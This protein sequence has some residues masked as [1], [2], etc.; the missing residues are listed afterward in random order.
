MARGRG[1]EVGRELSL[2]WDQ[3]EHLA[4]RGPAPS[5]AAPNSTAS[6][7]SAPSAAGSTPAPGGRRG[8]RL[9]ALGA[10]AALVL[11]LL[12]GLPRLG[13]GADGPEEVAR[14]FLQAMVDGDLETV[15]VH[16]R[17]VPDASPAALTAEVLE[18]AED[19]LVSAEIL[20][21][22]RVADTAT[23]T[24]RLVTSAT[25]RELV[26]PL[27]A[28]STGA[29]S[30]VRWEIVPIELPETLV[31]LPIDA[32]RIEVNGIPVEVDELDVDGNADTPRIALQLLPGTYEIA[33]PATSDWVEATTA[34]V[35]VPAVFG[36]WRKPVDLGDRMLSEAGTEELERRIDETLQA[37][38][39]APA[40]D[41]EP[42]AEGVPGELGDWSPGTLIVVEAAPLGDFLWRF[43]ASDADGTD[44]TPVE[45]V[46][47]AYLDGGGELRV[48]LGENSSFTYTTCVE[49]ET[50]KVTGIGLVAHP[51]DPRSWDVCG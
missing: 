44:A 39:Q 31:A 19:R 13:L 47:M 15:R 51:E 10:A 37:C 40:A 48:R 22:E 33:V 5:S 45:V 46:G 34:S 41:P 36:A 7:P 26:L 14:E 2:G 43:S 29:F 38:T 17:S 32:E 30:P 50:G 4:P 49:A 20:D 28:T 24:A 16:V 12:I 9:L 27:Q 11:A 1:R 21:V 8:R 3:P 25:E 42:C 23:V 18:A 35:T 6:E